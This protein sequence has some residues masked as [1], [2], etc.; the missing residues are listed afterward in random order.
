M[1]T[2]DSSLMSRLRALPR[3]AWVL[4]LGTFLNKFGTFVMPFLTLYLTQRGF[5]LGA[6]GMAISAYGIGSLMAAVM[7]GHLADKIGRRK[8]IALSMFSV[9]AAM[10]LLSQSRSLPAIIASTW[11]AALTGE[12]Y[13]PASSALLADLVP[14]ELRV[15]AYAAYRLAFNAGFA[16][17]PAMAGFLATRGYFWL[18]AGD[19]ATSVLFGLIALAALPRAL[20]S[21]RDE[22]S[23]GRDF[24]TLAGDQNLRRVL[25]ASFAIALVF[26]QISSTFSLHVTRLGF[27]PSTYGLILSL[28]GVLIVI[29]EL[30]MTSLTRRFP[31]RFMM[32]AG[33]LLVGAG[34]SLNAF[35]HQMSGLA[36]CVI[37]LTIG[38]MAAMPV[39]AAY[40]ADLAPPHLRGRYMGA[41]S[42]TWSAALIFAPQ[43]GLRLFGAAPG[44]L[45]L[46]CW[47]LAMVAAAI[48]C[49]AFGLR[50]K[51][52]LV[53]ES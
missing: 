15:T 39:T 36:A 52:G 14:S 24:K 41:Y 3:P 13:R 25:L 11:L 18:F 42:L 23:W 16:F 53:S 2:K 8:T 17:G 6:A 47:A 5:S 37:I 9:A 44:I 40:I 30:P 43:L 10:V 33:H 22:G 51:A 46:A 28:N 7:G 45:W 19:A 38:E 49:P 26:L 32:A 34:F 31:A 50:R 27:P 12:M 29:C 21:R 4:F 20:P 35:A 1:I 48:V